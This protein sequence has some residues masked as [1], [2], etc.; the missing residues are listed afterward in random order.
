MN[1]EMDWN[2]WDYDDSA[3]SSSEIM[4]DLDVLN[5]EELRSKSLSSD[6][7]YC[8]AAIKEEDSHSPFCGETIWD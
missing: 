2:L 3:S 8:G 5:E 6:G 4:S 1:E 7:V